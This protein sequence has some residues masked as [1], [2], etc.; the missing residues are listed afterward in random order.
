M[1]V[2]DKASQAPSRRGEKSRRKLLDAARKLFVERGYHD[3]R[4]QDISKAAGVGHGTFYLHFS[5]KRECF[6]SF[7][8]EAQEELQAAIDK[9]NDTSKPFE[10]NLRAVFRA[11][12]TYANA[13]PGVLTAAM[14][15][16]VV[17]GAPDGR[18]VPLADRWTV[19]WKAAFD[20][21]KERGLIDS[22]F[23]TGVLASSVV[24]Q[25]NALCIYAQRTG[26][27]VETILDTM[28]EAFFYGLPPK[29]PQ[30]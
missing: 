30:E 16:P 7:V 20:R 25:L 9:S 27:D 4:P 13:N 6:I 15:D 26:V 12:L 29:P 28:T 19:R 23:D 1:S 3:T 21:R 11:V 22:R 14:I 8:D 18:H 5:D 10:D 24:G 17:I 2:D